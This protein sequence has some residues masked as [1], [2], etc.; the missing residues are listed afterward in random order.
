MKICFIDPQ[1]IHYGLNTG[2]AYIV[3]YLKNIQGYDTLKVFDFNNKND[4]FASRINEIR[5]FDIIGFSIQSYT[6]ESALDIAHQVK[7]KKNILIAGGPHINLDGT[8]FIKINEIFDLAMIGEGEKRIAALLQAIEEKNSLE[9][10]KGIL[11]RKNKEIIYTGTPDRIIDLDSLPYPDYSD[12]DSIKNSKIHN[13]PLVTSRGCPY[14]CTYCCVKNV[15]G[16]QWIP[17]NVDNIIDELINARKKYFINSFNIRD[18]N[19]SLNMDRAKYLC[20]ELV[21]QSLNM[22][23]SCYLGMRADKIDTELM[24]KMKKS[25]CFAIS[26]G[27]ESAVKKEFEAIKKGEDFSDILKAIDIAHYNHI[28]V[29]GNFI[30]GLPHSNL[31]SIRTSIK[32]ATGL[33]LESCIFNLLVPFPG[34]EVWDWVKNH[35]RI[36]ND[37][38]EGFTMGKYP[39][40]VFETNEFPKRDRIKAY[41]EANTRCKNYF[42]FIDEHG[43]IIINIFYVIKTILQ[44]DF[45]HLFE[46]IVWCLK[47]Y[48]RITLRI[49]GK[50]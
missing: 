1:G 17:R 44:Y 16:K 5:S 10:I 20:G 11:Y 49:F 47:N 29:S 36:L 32:F 7:T 30:I 25:G 39:T 41:Y 46:H 15:I 26:L 37:W 14:Q 31:K 34:T 28:H 13:Y 33:R 9:S 48:K 22:K 2:L 8:N 18:D 27:I 38:H 23:W 19:F 12:F 42:A 21:K 4:D 3:S 45:F 40:I 6:Y 24:S 35:G 43:P 50:N